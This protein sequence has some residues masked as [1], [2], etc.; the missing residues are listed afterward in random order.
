[1]TTVTDAPGMQMPLELPDEHTRKGIW[2]GGTGAVGLLAA[3]FAALKGLFYW[4]LRVAKNDGATL[5][6]DSE[7]RKADAHIEDRQ[8]QINYNL[9]LGLQKDYARLVQQNED[10][11]HQMDAAEK[12]Y[13]VEIGNMREKNGE[14][15]GHVKVLAT[16]SEKQRLWSHAVRTI[17]TALYVQNHLLRRLARG[18]MLKVGMTDDEIKAEIPE[19]MDIPHEILPVPELPKDFTVGGKP[20]K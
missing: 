1:M 3:L 7:E 10:Q 20:Q 5:E 9:I 15:E 14:L 8:S 11:Q 12:R 18:M 6:A 2:I 19:E 4:R 16:E 17:A 13:L